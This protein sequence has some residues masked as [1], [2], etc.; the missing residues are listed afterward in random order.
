M[1]RIL[2][3]TGILTTF[4]IFAQQLNTEQNFDH[5]CKHYPKDLPF[6]SFAYRND[7]QSP[8]L[9]YYDISYYFLD[10]DVDHTSVHVGGTVEIH[11]KVTAP[12]LDTFAFELITA[13]TI[14]AI[15]INTTEYTSYSRD[16][17]N[18]LVPIEAVP[19]GEQ[20]IAQ[21]SYEGTPPS[22]GFFSG[23]SNATSSTWQKSVTWT[24]SEPFGAKEWFPCKQVLTD[25]ADSV[26]VHLSTAENTIAVS[27]GLLENTVNLPDNRIRYE[28]KSNYPIAYYLISFAVSDYQDYSIFAHPNQMEGDSILIQNFVYNHPDYLSQNK[29]KIDK[30]V[31][32][33]ELF[34]D[35]FNLYP[36]AGEKYGHAICQL[37]GGMEHQ[38]ITTIGS[39]DFDLIAHE[40]AHMW[41]GDNV[42]CASWSDVWINEGFATYGNYLAQA[43]IY[44]NTAGKNFIVR[45]QNNVMTQS[46]GSVY[47]P[48]SEVHPD[49]IG[50]IF[51]GR[52]SY[53]KGA[54]IIHV[55]RHEINDDEVF[56]DILKSFQTKFSDSTATAEDF[57]ELAE[58]VS[59]MELRQFFDQWYYGEGYPLYEIEWNMKDNILKMNVTQTTSSTTALFEMSMSYKLNY[60]DG[61]SEIIR[62]FQ[63]ENLK[64]FEVPLSKKVISIEVDPENWTFEKVINIINSITDL[65]N[66][67]FFTFGPNPTADKIKIYTKAEG[68]EIHCS[69]HDLSGRLILNQEIAASGQEINVSSLAAGNYIIRLTTANQSWNKKLIKQ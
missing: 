6:E 58:E 57:K 46:G 47:V 17:D 38:T 42:T 62:L 37:G 8:L 21:I 18:V 39:F 33:L 11:A 24:L 59:G 43:M 45:T 29:S 54:S 22:G 1:R 36:F 51:N 12:I 50:R 52:L 32:M 64:Q 10:L 7:W 69:I 53:H 60:E 2:L 65:D 66:P 23:I 61:S 13:H 49:N 63:D 67:A 55:L 48:P 3:I 35:L 16:G 25:K 34:S 28:W 26:R 31:P 30:T 44:G 20:F 41:F 5:Y 9:Q 15:R 14:H 27:Q 4:N 56:F 68:K 19:Q 40:L